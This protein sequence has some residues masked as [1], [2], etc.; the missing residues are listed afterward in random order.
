MP[1]ET[2]FIATDLHPKVYLCIDEHGFKRYY[3]GQGDVYLGWSWPHQ[4]KPTDLKT[5]ESYL[6]QK[7]A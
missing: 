4:N 5:M 6:N 2:T 3:L 1:K 7:A